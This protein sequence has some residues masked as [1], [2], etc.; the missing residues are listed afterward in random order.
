MYDD[1]NEEKKISKKKKKQKTK[2]VRTPN[3][4]CL[5]NTMDTLD[6]VTRTQNQKL[7]FYITDAHAI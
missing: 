5:P 4:N 3:P 1:W 7:Y 6:F 2:T